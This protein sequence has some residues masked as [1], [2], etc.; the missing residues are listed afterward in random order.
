MLS[1]I[2][3]IGVVTALVLSLSVTTLSDSNANAAPPTVM[4]GKTELKLGQIGKVT[5]NSR[6]V[7][8]KLEK[9]NTLTKVRDLK[10]GEEFRVYSYKSM[11]GGLYGVGGGNFIYKSPVVKY[12]TPSKSKLALLGGQTPVVTLPTPK[13]NPVTTNPVVAKDKNAVYKEKL[14]TIKNTKHKN[15]K[16]YANAV[17]KLHS[18][19]GKD[20]Y[21]LHQELVEAYFQYGIEVDE[22]VLAFNDG[23]KLL[24]FQRSPESYTYNI[25]NNRSATFYNDEYYLSIPILEYVLNAAQDTYWYQD[26]TGSKEFNGKFFI[27]GASAQPSTEF[28][29]ESNKK[30]GYYNVLKLGGYWNN[31]NILTISEREF[32][33][34]SGGAGLTWSSIINPYTNDEIKQILGI[35]FD[36]TYD[37]TNNRMTFHF[38]KPLKQKN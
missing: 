25:S 18:E 23:A 4:W 7:L 27:S 31:P 13:P 5:I 11:E 28:K 15:Y 35:E 14:N 17:F 30:A 24:A 2:T 33:F 38:D 26:E 36:M 3:K 10:A 32:P 20:N 8:Y 22:V 9:D 37:K 34:V 21:N 29:D 12:E 1:R 6:T 19:A 16:E